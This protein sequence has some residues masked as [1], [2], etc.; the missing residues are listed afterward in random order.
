M[1]NFM[2]TMRKELG[3]PNQPVK[4]Q[5]TNNNQNKGNTTNQPKNTRPRNNSG[6]NN[7]P[8]NTRSRNNNQPKNTRPRNNSGNNNQPKNT[9]IINNGIS[10]GNK[11]NSTKM[12]GGR[13]RKIRKGPRG[14]KYYIK[15][16]KKVYV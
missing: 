5:K 4:K 10:S 2:Q 1:G 3:L 16:G 8:K 7:Q 14:G 12:I 15:K 6:N 9:T 13:K 11:P